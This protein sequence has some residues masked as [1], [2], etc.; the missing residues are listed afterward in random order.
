M[1]AQELTEDVRRNEEGSNEP[2][3]GVEG[4][5]AELGSG[6]VVQHSR[7]AS[8]RCW[9][10]LGAGDVQTSRQPGWT[11]AETSCAML[12]RTVPVRRATDL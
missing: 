9:E 4:H 11:V 6:D 12:I 5:S 10:L 7:P 1:L 8:W 3:G 2:D